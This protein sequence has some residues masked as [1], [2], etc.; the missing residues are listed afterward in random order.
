MRRAIASSL[1]FYLTL[2]SYSY[3]LIKKLILSLVFLDS[4]THFSNKSDFAM[5][6]DARSDIKL[7]ITLRPLVCVVRSLICLGSCTAWTRRIAIKEAISFPVQSAD[8][9]RGEMAW[10]LNMLNRAALWAVSRRAAATGGA[11]RRL[12]AANLIGED[13]SENVN[14]TTII[15]MFSLRLV[16]F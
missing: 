6:M 12:C 5:G 9:W 2:L 16:L 10:R 1:S 3:T 8:N 15:T 4:A 13:S 14:L 11:L 7:C